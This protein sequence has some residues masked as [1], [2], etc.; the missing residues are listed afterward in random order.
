MYKRQSKKPVSNDDIQWEYVKMVMWLFAGM[1]YGYFI[2]LGRRFE[3][4]YYKFYRWFC[5]WCCVII[6]NGTDYIR[7][8]EYG[9]R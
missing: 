1:A 5:M 4:R 8:N 7:T 9:Y 2:I 3:K 6:Y